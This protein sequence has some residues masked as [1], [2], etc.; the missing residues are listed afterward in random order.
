MAGYGNC[1]EALWQAPSAPAHFREKGT[2]YSVA[3]II[4]TSQGYEKIGL[5]CLRKVVVGK[6]YAGERDVRFDVAEAGNGLS[7]L[8]R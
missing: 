1:Q 6:P 5:E 8:L 3:G 7:C 4:S 2:V